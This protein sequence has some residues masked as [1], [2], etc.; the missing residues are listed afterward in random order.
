MALSPAKRAAAR[1]EMQAQRSLPRYLTVYEVAA[2]MQRHEITVYEWA[3]H[4]PERLPRVTRI[5]DRVL[6]DARDVEAWFDA[7]RGDVIA[8]PDVAAET[9][10]RRPGRPTKAEQ[11]RRRNAARSGA[12]VHQ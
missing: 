6:F 2:L 12:V 11:A 9:P 7:Q 1:A 8:V 3:R 4:A 5:A 10:K